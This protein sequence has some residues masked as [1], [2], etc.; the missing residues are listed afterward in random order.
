MTQR[1]SKTRSGTAVVPVSLMDMG[2][3]RR[4]PADFLEVGVIRRPHG[5]RG[6]LR[7]QLH[8]PSSHALSGRAQLLLGPAAAARLFEIEEARELSD[9]MWLVRLAGVTGRDEAEALRGAPILLH[10]DDL[11]PLDDGE[12]YLADLPGLRVVTASGE[13]M[14]RVTEVLHLPAQDLLV[15]ARPPRPEALVPLVYV[16]SVDTAAGQLTID[17]PEGL[18]DLDLT[19]ASPARAAKGDGGKGDD[20]QRRGD[21]EM[22]D[23]RKDR[24]C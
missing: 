21:S 5:V 16:E 17:P 3:Q 23:A 9:G 6:Q 12:F 11:P 18:L 20:S 7:V 13:E 22:G 15:I 14:G 8:D 1:S 2:R 10:R 19:A 24:P 4:D